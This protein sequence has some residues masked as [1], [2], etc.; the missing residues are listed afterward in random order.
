MHVP[1]FPI[2]A[3]AHSSCSSP[4]NHPFDRLQVLALVGHHL[5]GLRPRVNCHKLP[6]AF[7]PSTDRTPP[8]LSAAA[9]SVMAPTKPTS[10][11]TAPA[12]GT[13]R[14]KRLPPE[15]KNPEPLPT[16]QAARRRAVQKRSV[17]RAEKQ[18]AKV[19][20]NNSLSPRQR[21]CL[22]PFRLFFYRA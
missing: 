6:S 13:K 11:A 19:T 14:S 8:S 1:S 18:A 16:K 2:H 3:G 4:S 15:S 12:A 5:N 17:N 9:S 20:K 21:A 10:K 22:R 7:K